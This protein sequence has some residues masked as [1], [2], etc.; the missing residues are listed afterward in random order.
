MS[1][2]CRLKKSERKPFLLASPPPP[3]AIAVPPLVRRSVLHPH[4]SS[5]SSR[6]T[7]AAPCPLYTSRPPLFT[8]GVATAAGNDPSPV[9]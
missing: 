8:A 1:T 3:L 7:A 9:P 4:P 6:F 2:C 5:T